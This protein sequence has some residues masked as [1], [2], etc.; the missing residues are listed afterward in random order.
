MLQNF[1]VAL[2]VVAAALYAAWRLAGAAARLRWL[3]ALARRVGTSG[4]VAA[5]LQ[6]QL[7]RRRAALA[8]SGCGA[9]A[10]NKSGKTGRA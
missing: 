9:C 8:I 4:P 5:L 3:E 1:I 7:A 2:I 10:S 6:R